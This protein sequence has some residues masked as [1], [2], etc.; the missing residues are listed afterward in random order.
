MNE[1]RSRESQ[2]WIESLVDRFERPLLAYSCRLL[3]GD[4]VRAQDAVQ[5]TFLRL[6]KLRREDRAQVQ[7]RV[8]AWLFAVCRTRVIDMQRSP[9]YAMNSTDHLPLADPTPDASELAET[10]EQTSQLASLV[11]TLSPRQ[12]EVLRLRLQAELSYREIAEITGLTV[13]NVGFHLH[14][15]V[16]SL[17]EAMNPA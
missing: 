14:A 7:P 1:L 13:S 15:A 12:Q 6:L 11:E 5:E 3:G 4:P 16:R 8:A 17:R 2:A 9:G 10:A